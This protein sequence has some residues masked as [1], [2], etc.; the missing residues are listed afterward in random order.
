ME[1]FAVI[2]IETTGL[3]PEKDKLVEIARVEVEEREIRS[4]DQS[5]AD[6][7]I[8]IPPEASAIHHLTNEML[9]NAPSPAQA[10]TLILP[11][12]RNVICVAHNAKFDSAFL[13]SGHRWICTKKLAMRIWPE[14][15]AHNNQVLRY[16][17]KVQFNKAS[18]RAAEINP[19]RAL[20]DAFVTAHLFLLLMDEIHWDVNVALEI[21][22]NPA[23]LPVCHFGKHKG[24]RWESVP[25]DYLAWVVRQDMDEDVLF[26]ANHYLSR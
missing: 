21:S 26:T 16:W 2:D 23:L 18:R 20:H 6:P 22:N 25:R 11:S 17:K 7:G 10:I 9:D 8:P 15:P 5:W 1:K 19:H 12:N 4:F 13:P 24:E 14:A 3:D